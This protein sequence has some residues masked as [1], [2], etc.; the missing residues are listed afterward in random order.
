MGE[1]PDQEIDAL[2]AR[3]T[4]VDERLVAALNERIELVAELKHA[5]VERGI[6]FHDPEREAWLLDHLAATSAGPVSD[7]GLREIFQRVLALTKRE[8]G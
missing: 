5:K 1:E 7:E 8:L 3:L 6:D 2:R 4:A